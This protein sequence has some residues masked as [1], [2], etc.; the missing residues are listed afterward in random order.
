MSMLICHNIVVLWWIYKTGLNMGLGCETK[1]DET[2]TPFSL[3]MCTNMTQV[4]YEQ[5]SNL[6]EQWDLFW[7]VSLLLL[8]C[9]P[10]RLRHPLSYPGTF[11]WDPMLD[12]C[13]WKDTDGNGVT[14]NDG[15][16]NVESGDDFMGKA[17]IQKAKLQILG[18]LALDCCEER[19]RSRVGRWVAVLSNTMTM[20][21]KRWITMT[22]R[23]K[24]D[25][26]NFMK[27]L[28]MVLISCHHLHV[29]LLG[30]VQDARCSRFFLEQHIRQDGRFP[31]SWCHSIIMMPLSA[32]QTP[33]EHAF[34]LLFWVRPSPNLWM[35]MTFFIKAS[36]APSPG[37]VSP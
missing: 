31:S 29:G 19:Y 5:K 17:I 6:C 14:L 20:G 11:D 7:F 28:T 32:S 33:P 3:W 22:R 16:G 15:N 1:N 4:K 37:P 13:G 12:K 10:I 27:M 35:V 36:L 9:V 26:A 2:A 18:E 30:N 8:G 24:Q 23:G 21:M 34:S 25:K